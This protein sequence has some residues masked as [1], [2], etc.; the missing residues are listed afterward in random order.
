MEEDGRLVP[1]ASFI[2]TLES[3]RK[4]TALSFQHP[5]EGFLA[6]AAIVVAVAALEQKT[7][8]L[9]YG[10]MMNEARLR[11]VHRD[12][13]EVGHFLQLSPSYIERL[14]RLF[15][16]GGYA[17]DRNASEVHDLASLVERRNRLVHV[18]DRALAVIT[19]TDDGYELRAPAGFSGNP[20]QSTVANDAHNAV[21]LVA[22][23]MEALEEGATPPFLKRQH[24]E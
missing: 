21:K 16:I 15:A 14:H 10:H 7:L 23:F 6:G 11:D 3:A 17:L 18:E 24:E 12:A 22:R 2:Y 4:L 9:L 19:R 13:T 20:W 1:I 5:T 8:M